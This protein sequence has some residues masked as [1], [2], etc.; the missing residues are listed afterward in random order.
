MW[1]SWTSVLSDLN[2]LKQKKRTIFHNDDW[3]L[4]YKIYTLTSCFSEDFFWP[5][6]WHS[7]CFK[8]YGL[9]LSSWGVTGAWG[10][11]L[12]FVIHLLSYFPS[13][14]HWVSDTSEGFCHRWHWD[15]FPWLTAQH[16]LL[17]CWWQ[18]TE[19]SESIVSPSCLETWISN[20]WSK[21]RL[22]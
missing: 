6:A 16:W 3:T 17:F 14:K 20:V 1:E 4:G 11:C 9:F 22:L 18:N 19:L 12:D 10:S 5:K 13:T 7:S 2:L 8:H 21:N 15:I